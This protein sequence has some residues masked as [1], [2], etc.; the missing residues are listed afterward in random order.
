MNKKIIIKALIIGEIVLYVSLAIAGYFIWRGWKE[1]SALPLKINNTYQPVK[2]VEVENELNV[3]PA[4]G[5]QSSPI[6]VPAITP[7]LPG[8]SASVP[9]TVSPSAPTSPQVP[10]PPALPPVSTPIS[11]PVPSTNPYPVDAEHCSVFDA[12]PNINYC[13]LAP[14]QYA[15]YIEYCEQCKS[16]GF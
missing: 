7:S 8:A 5:G 14:A 12:V 9:E 1:Y 10:I 3:N 16:A 2:S 6:A 11:E 13:K 15:Q 4:N